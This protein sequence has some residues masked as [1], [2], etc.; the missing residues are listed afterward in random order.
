MRYPDNILAEI[1]EHLSS[2]RNKI[3]TTLSSLKAQDPFSDPERLI[4]NAASDTEAK[5][6]SSHERMEA[7][8]KELRQHLNDIEKA[9]DRVQKGSYGKCLNCG[10][11]I[12]TDRLAIKP[13]A[14]LCV[15]CERKK[16]S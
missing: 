7:L 3:K 13:T 2:E 12:D 8:E 9:L 15:V 6:E 16:E 11:M 1:K 5:E 10:K 14:L 4:D